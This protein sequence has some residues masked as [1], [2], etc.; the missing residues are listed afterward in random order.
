MGRRYRVAG[1]NVHVIAAQRDVR[2]RRRIKKTWLAVTDF[3]ADDRFKAVPAGRDWIN[4]LWV[5]E[6]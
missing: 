3:A 5:R 1:L 6:W 2:G 4:W